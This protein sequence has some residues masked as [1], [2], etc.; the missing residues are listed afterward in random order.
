MATT[1]HPANEGLDFF[2]DGTID[3]EVL[4]NYLSRSMTVSDGL[5]GCP[6][7]CSS[8]TEGTDEFVQCNLRMILNTGVKYAGRAGCNWEVCPAAINDL[9]NVKAY[10]DQAHAVDPDILFEACIFECIATKLNGIPV[11]PWAF[12]AF[13]LTPENRNFRYDEMLFPD[14]TYVDHW[15][16][17]CSVPD[18]TRQET[19]IFFYFLGRSY[20]DAGFEALHMGQVHLIGRNDAGWKYYTQLNDMLRAYAKSHARRHMVLINSHT[21]GIIDANGMLMFD[22]HEWPMR[23]KVPEGSV[24]HKPTEEHPLELVLEVGY[25]DAI[26]Q[27]SMGG[28]TYSGWSCDHLPYTVEID[29]YGIEPD[30]LND[31]VAP[32]WGYDEISWFAHQPASYRHKWL[33]YAHDWVRGTDPVGHF[34]MPGVRICPTVLED[35]SVTRFAYHNYDKAFFNGV[36]FDDEA[37]IREIFIQ[38]RKK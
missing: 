6:D 37:T 31:P 17:G 12:E 38:S 11:P 8:E 28:K 23:G 2:F 7:Y 21:H 26:Y 16:P 1:V 18:I 35:G 22:F 10:I 36:G 32:H 15:E 3:K 29:N 34:M 30:R 27:K 33:K 19:R 4:C 5:N 24:K 25:G 14:G 9:V 20:I 13:G